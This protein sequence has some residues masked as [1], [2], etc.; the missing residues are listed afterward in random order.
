MKSV[1]DEVRNAPR[2]PD[3][4]AER[5]LAEVTKELVAGTISRRQV[6]R[7]IGGTLAGTVLARFSGS[8]S[9]ATTSGETAP[10]VPAQHGAMPRGLLLPAKNRSLEGR[11]GLMFKKLPAF[12]PPDVLLSEL[13][14]GMEEGSVT[15]SGGS[16]LPSDLVASGF[17]FL[18]QFIDHDLT[19][20]KTPL[21]LQRQD[22]DAVT[23]FRAA[24]LGLDS[25]YGAGPSQN[26]E[27]YDPNDPA[28]LLVVGDDLPRRPDGTAIIGDP[29]DDENVVTSQL[30]LAFRK[31]HNALV[32]HVREQGLSRI[33]EVFAEAQRLCR[34]HYQWMVL[35]D[36]LPTI[37]NRN[38]VDSILQERGNAPAKVKLD[39]YKP[40]NPNK[41]MM[42][43]EF[44]V[45]AY[46]FG[47]SM[48]RSGYVINKQGERAVLFEDT[49]T[50][51]N[52]NGGRPIP[53]ALVIFWPRFFKIS[54]ED[55]T[56]V[57][58]ARPID[59]RLSG[60]LFNLPIPTLPPPSTRRSLAERNLL[61][62]K[63][64][65]LASGQ[66]VAQEMGA[67]VL[68]NADLIPPDLRNQPGWEGQAPLWF[69][70]L[71]EAELRHGGT[72][73]GTV[74]GRIVAEVFV[75][76]LERDKSSYLS[77][78]PAFRP[79]RPVARESGVFGMGDLL[80]FAGVA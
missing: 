7:W 39:F 16:S 43:V 32:E 29:R 69:Y 8:A 2:Q 36:F 52:L 75:G 63:M 24:S 66:H 78:D 80:K 72:K 34:W 6:L 45:A 73:L 47:H 31:F 68:S 21:D 4:P 60:P 14:G 64:L 58:S 15:E 26:P 65:G 76:L 48:L 56:P 33:D 13:A 59:G 9:A 46:R 71:K 28:K 12:R 50:D 38:V 70:I 77:V 1:D 25:V 30:H 54:D 74:G 44:A 22:P 18:G 35:H 57:N 53:D 11:F 5:S 20:D 42:P 49:P 67:E 19:F 27:Y 40:K 23:N 79:Q 41:P 3:A 10:G 62:G 61:R 37:V 51:S 17:V 55:S